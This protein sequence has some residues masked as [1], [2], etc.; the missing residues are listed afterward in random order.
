MRI[1]ETHKQLII[2]KIINQLKPFMS[3]NRP[4]RL[5]Q[6][7]DD[8]VTKTLNKLNSNE[9]VSIYDLLAEIIDRSSK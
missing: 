1:G 3:V 4:T 9:L 5:Y 2:E 6:L 7:Y 8:Q